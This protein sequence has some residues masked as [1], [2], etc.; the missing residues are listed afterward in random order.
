MGLE[1]LHRSLMSPG[2]L[3]KRN[4][5]SNPKFVAEVLK[6]KLGLIRHEH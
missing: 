6:T 5:S 1:W 2:R 4:A 3:G